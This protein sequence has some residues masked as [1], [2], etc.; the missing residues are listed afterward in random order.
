MYQNGKGGRRDVHGHAGSSLGLIDIATM[1]DIVQWPTSLPDHNEWDEGRQL[2]AQHV[3][4]SV[5]APWRSVAT[6]QTSAY[7]QRTREARRILF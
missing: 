2:F 5:L 6:L 1:S 4:F 3:N 7:T